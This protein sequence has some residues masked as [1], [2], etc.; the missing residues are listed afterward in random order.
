MALLTALPRGA[1]PAG[2]RVVRDRRGATGA[3]TGA[4]S[5]TR[6]GVSPFARSRRAP[7]VRA[8]VVRAALRLRPRRRPA[9]GRSCGPGGFAGSVRTVAAARTVPPSFSMEWRSRGIQSAAEVPH[10]LPTA[11]P[12]RP[13]G[14]Q[15]DGRA[16]L[17]TDRGIAR[18]RRRL[19]AS[20]SP[21]RRPCA[22]G[23]Q[24]P[25][26]AGP[27]LGRFGSWPGRG[28]LGAVPGAMCPAGAEAA[29]APW[30]PRRRGRTPGPRRRGCWR[31]RRP[32]SGAPGPSRRRAGRARAWIAWSS[33]PHAAAPAARDT[34]SVPPGAVGPWS[35]PQ[36]R[37]RSTSGTGTDR[38]GRRNGR[39]AAL[40]FRP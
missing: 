30:T 1:G 4:P 25:L 13:G 18:G 39:S 29:P 23:H 5:N 31:P 8:A 28:G 12:S 2:R 38:P 16:L 34:L 26:L 6:G 7:S 36:Q 15:V 37:E 40:S 35:G 11:R 3:L 20:A 14:G 24:R 27:R 21:G 10:A 19:G 32:G 22:C 33:V 17:R 9:R